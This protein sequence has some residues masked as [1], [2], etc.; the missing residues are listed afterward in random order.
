METN[1]KA[2]CSSL[3]DVCP[4]PSLLMVPEV[5]ELIPVVL[6]HLLTRKRIL[7]RKCSVLGCFFFL[8]FCVCEMNP[9]DG[10]R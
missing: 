7:K 1:Y 3:P 5:V 6:C 9:D 4:A 2:K 8:L 10:Y